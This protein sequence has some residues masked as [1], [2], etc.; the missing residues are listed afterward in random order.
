MLAAIHGSPQVSRMIL[1]VLRR[2]VHC[3]CTTI[4]RP[5]GTIQTSPNV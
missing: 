3:F 4:P 2:R 1:R 5:Q